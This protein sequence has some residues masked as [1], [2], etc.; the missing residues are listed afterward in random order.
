VTICAGGLTAIEKS[1][2]AGVTVIVRVGGLGSELPLASMRVSEA[3]YVPGALKVTL[4]GLCPTDVAGE[5][6]GKTHE[7]RAAVV[8]ELKETDPPAGMVTSEAGD[9]IAPTGGVVA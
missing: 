9:A 5:P 1:A 4:P 2:V 6:P 8:L 7:Y 3:T